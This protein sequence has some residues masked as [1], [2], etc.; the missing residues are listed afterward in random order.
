L[1]VLGIDPGSI[2]TG[3]GFV[4]QE[5]GHLLCLAYGEIKPLR[6]AALTAC[7]TTVYDALVEAI[8]RFSPDVMVVENN[9]YGKNVS[10]LIKQG[11]VRGVAVLAGACQGIPVVEYS[12]LE[13]KKA[14]AG[15]GFAEKRQVQMM[16]KAILKLAEPPPPDAA[17]ALAAAVCHINF[18]KTHW[19]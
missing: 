9:F 5:D 10:S 12:P 18:S 1:I 16:I 15:Y 2:T 14:V 13:I 4:Q 6:G 8:R 17:D 3:Y 19:I 11:H 7:L